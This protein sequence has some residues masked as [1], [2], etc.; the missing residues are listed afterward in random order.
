MGQRV[1]QADTQTFSE[2]MVDA[3]IVTVDKRTTM[4]GHYLRCLITARLLLLE[5]FAANVGQ[6]IGDW[7]P[8]VCRRWLMAQLNGGTMISKDLFVVLIRGERVTVE[9]ICDSCV[10][11]MQASPVCLFDEAHGWHDEST[12]GTFLTTS[13]TPAPAR[14]RRTLFTR[15]VFL[16]RQLRFSSLWVGTALSI[17]DLRPVQSAM[18]TMITDS[19]H[20]HIVA[21]FRALS[22]REVESTLCHFLRVSGPTAR[23]LSGELAGRGRTTAEFLVYCWKQ[24]AHAAEDVLACFGAFRDTVFSVG[25]RIPSEPRR[26]EQ[27]KSL[28]DAWETLLLTKSAGTMRFARGSTVPLSLTLSRPAAALAASVGDGVSAA[29]RDWRKQAL[30]LLHRVLWNGP[31]RFRLELSSMHVLVLGRPRRTA[32]RITDTVRLCAPVARAYLLAAP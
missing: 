11:R 12:Y 3:Q 32:R 2:E 28:S 29:G 30:E 17:G 20:S 31:T 26:P 27:A 16:V 4:A 23:L 25:E 22:P 5:H 24:G 13:N 18:M 10:T 14:E 1:G 21:G 9:S 6:R 7:S 19:L 15:A 8:D